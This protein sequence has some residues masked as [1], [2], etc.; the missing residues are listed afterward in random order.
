MIGLWQIVGRVCFDSRFHYNLLALIQALPKNKPETDEEKSRVG[1]AKKVFYDYLITERKYL[2]SRF[3]FELL[4]DLLS[5]KAIDERINDIRYAWDERTKLDRKG[6]SILG[7]ACLDTPFCKEIEEWAE[8]EP[9]EPF[10]KKMVRFDATDEDIKT[11]HDFFKR[12]EV[13]EL[14]EPFER[15]GWTKPGRCAYSFTFDPEFDLDILLK[16]KKIRMGWFCLGDPGRA[17][18]DCTIRAALEKASTLML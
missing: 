5:N 3:E 15:E 8:H 7:L 1:A 14:V 2:M 17:R 9:F 10:R 12:K 18:I 6:S 4:I 11:L 16:E 13:H